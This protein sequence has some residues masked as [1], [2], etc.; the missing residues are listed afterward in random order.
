MM[1]ILITTFVLSLSSLGLA[2][3]LKTYEIHI[4]NNRFEPAELK[5]AKNTPFE[6]LVFNDDKTAEEF[7]SK[8]LRK[9][10]IIP[11]GK[12]A[13]FKIGAL[14]PGIYNFFGEFHED[15]AKGKI[16]VE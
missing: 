8:E 10:K 14:K 13:K 15:T 12:S 2:E 6:L 4:K 7:E 3:E 16:I 1:K 11:G 9:E 5:V